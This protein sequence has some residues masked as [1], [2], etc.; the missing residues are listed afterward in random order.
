M[1]RETLKIL[2]AALLALAAG[3][4]TVTPFPSASP[5]EGR[6]RVGPFAEFG[7]N[8]EGVTVNA[9]RPFY[10]ETRAGGAVLRDYAAPLG[11]SLREENVSRGRALNV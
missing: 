11:Y 6:A 10:V 5:H 7:K 4:R 2:C 3:C 1:G 8:A 9:A